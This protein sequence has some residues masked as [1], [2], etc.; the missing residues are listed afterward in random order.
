MFSLSLSVLSSVSPTPS[1]T[2][3]DRYF[4]I[5]T[6]SF[7]IMS[8]RVQLLPYIN[9]VQGGRDASEGDRRVVSVE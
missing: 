3:F 2:I 1:M 4:Y 9:K 8:A 6:H 7:M 5:Y